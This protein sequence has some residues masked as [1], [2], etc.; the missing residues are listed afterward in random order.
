MR[1]IH[2]PCLF[3]ALCALSTP[4]A[5]GQNRFATIY[6]FNGSEAVG[7]TPINGVFYSTGG[8]NTCGA[9]IALEPPSA[10]GLEWTESTI[11]T[12]TGINGDGC[13]PEQPPAA[14][15]NGALYGITSGGGDSIWGTVYQLQPPAT[16]GGA[17]TENIL[18]SFPTITT[19]LG[20]MVGSDGVLY[21]GCQNG[22]DHG[23]G[24]IFKLQPPAT[25]GGAWM[26]SV[27]YSF[28][29]SLTESNPLS[30]TMGPQGL[31]YGTI[32]I[33][34]NS[35]TNA[36]AV[37]EIKPPSAPGGA[38]TETVLYDFH[39][40]RDGSTPNSLVVAGGGTIYGTTFGT[41]PLDGQHGTHG[42]GTV[43]SL[44]PPATSG[45]TWTKTI[46]AQLSDGDLRG[47][48]SPLILHNGNLYGTSTSGPS[49]PGGVVFELQPATAPG[50]GW[51][52][53]F[54]HSF[55]GAIPNGPLF[56]DQ[57]GAVYGTTQAPSGAPPQGVVYKIG[58]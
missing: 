57:D 39:A 26:T 24:A 13:G 3:A 4:C 21:V 44:T 47:P 36:G 2:L 10:P 33:G 14:G 58:P 22:G 16:A 38:W 50:G 11:Y 20:L 46:L 18:Y 12:F 43:F 30:F 41:T 9:I 19:P 17:W 8:A 55:A 37:F 51:T 40:G 49:N 25:A 1:I 32:G 28:P 34:G 54:L 31:F 45:A 53:T 29:G 35:S 56:V 5:T 6:N 48:N 15:P 42:V 23:T 27:L 52:T 7:L